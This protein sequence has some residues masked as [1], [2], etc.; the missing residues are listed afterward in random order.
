MGIEDQYVCLTFSLHTALLAHYYLGGDEN[1]AYNITFSWWLQV[2]IRCKL[3]PQYCSI[4]FL[5]KG[6]IL[7]WLIACL[8]DVSQKWS[9]VKVSSIEG[10]LSHWE[11]KRLHPVM[12]NANLGTF[13][14]QAKNYQVVL[15]SP[16][17]QFWVCR[18]LWARHK[19]VGHCWLLRRGSNIILKQMWS[20]STQIAIRFIF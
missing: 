6:K 18:R 20:T 19:D 2:N 14:P 8:I 13:A 3:I 16:C 17:V 1:I 11:A 5:D 10:M 15:G 9:R 7:F 4:S 12:E